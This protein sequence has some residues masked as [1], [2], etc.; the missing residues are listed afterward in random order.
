[1]DIFHHVAFNSE[2][3]SEGIFELLGIKHEKTLRP[4]SGNYLISFNIYESHPAWSQVE[5]LIK[6][7]NAINRYETV[8]TKEEQLAA[9]WL[10]F[11]PLLERGYPKPENTW[12]EKTYDNVCPRCAAGYVQK[13]PFRMGGEPRMGKHDFL[14]LYWTWTAFC[15]Q[16]VLE[17]FRENSFKG[18]D[19]LP[20]LISRE[21]DISQSISQLIF[22]H[23][24][25][26]GL[27]DEDK[28]I[29]EKEPRMGFCPVCGIT[30][31]SYHNRGY[32]HIKREALV[33]DVDFQLTYE[34]FGS[35]THR[36]FLISNRVAKLILD[37]G[38]LR[39]LLKPV[40]LI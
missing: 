40:E 2:D 26:P 10:R 36:E 33:M 3:D 20:V 1:L 29:D 19:T 25:G 13:A 24:A 5:E 17:A 32:M 39:V 22:P 16:R 21:G 4:R 12:K 6:I 30:K 28:V 23:V 35:I 15:T 7:T 34:W 14:S 9:E 37:S 31:Y 18:Y 38:W 11:S 27:A 8:F